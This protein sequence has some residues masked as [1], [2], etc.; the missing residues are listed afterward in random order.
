MTNLVG[1]VPALLHTLYPGYLHVNT[2]NVLLVQARAL[3]ITYHSLELASWVCLQDNVFAL[4]PAE[5]GKESL[6]LQ[7]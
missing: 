4:M 6:C 1:S 2:Q 3:D 7:P 5:I